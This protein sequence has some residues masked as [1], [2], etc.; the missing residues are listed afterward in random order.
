MGWKYC[1][2]SL[3]TRT[4][5]LP[6]DP[7][8]GEGADYPHYSDTLDESLLKL[9]GEPVRWTVR[10]LDGPLLYELCKGTEYQMSELHKATTDCEWLYK[11]V[12]H[13]IC[14]VTGLGDDWPKTRIVQQEGRKVLSLEIIDGIRYSFP[15]SGMVA[16]Q[17]LVTAAL[18]LYADLVALQK[19]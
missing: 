18:A 14:N 15:D 8:I 17:I 12:R 4:I 5:I 13:V 7:A 10:P 11:A 9:T 16:V 6:D 2:P 3:T 1:A 19:K